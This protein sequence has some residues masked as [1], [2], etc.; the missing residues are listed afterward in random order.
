MHTN[1]LK[2]EQAFQFR[3]RT[4]GEKVTIGIYSGDNLLKK[5]KMRHA[6]PSEMITLKIPPIDP[7]LIN[8]EIH[9]EIISEESK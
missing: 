3:V 5:T 8:E 1:A 2:T 7:S 4:P 6:L 9:I